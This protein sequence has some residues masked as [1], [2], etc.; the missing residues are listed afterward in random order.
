[1]KL[2]RLA[3]Y[4]RMALRLSPN[5]LAA[6]VSKK[7]SSEV[8]AISS[9]QRDWLRSTYELAP[10]H[11]FEAGLA[12]RCTPVAGC[13]TAQ[14]IEVIREI[15]THYLAHRFDLLG[16]G[17]VQVR[18]GMECAGLEGHRYPPGSAVATDPHG[19]WLAGRLNRSNVEA[20]Q[21]VWKLV[22][23]DYIPID[24]HV[25][26]KSGYRWDEK[27]WYRNIRF[28]QLQGVDV[29]VPWELARMQH[30]PHLAHAYALAAGG[31]EGFASPDD[32]AREFQNQVLDF[33]ST[34]PPRY[35]VN[36]ACTMDVGIRIANWLLARD[37]FIASGA[38]LDDKFE[39]T[40]IQSVYQH[41]QHIIDNLEWRVE[42]R[43]NHYLSDIVGLLFVAAYLPCSAK[44]D[45]WL[46]FSI[47]E[48]IVEVKGQFYEDG[49]NF[50][51][52]TSY[53]RL[54]AELVVYGSALIVG[55]PQSKRNATFSYDCSL[56]Q[57]EPKLNQAPLK[58]FAI[59]GSNIQ[60]PL[61]EWYWRRLERM[62][63][64]TF[65]IARPDG[66]SPQIGDNDSGRLFK[67]SPNYELL[68]F[69]EVRQRYENL[70]DVQELG[71]LKSY[72]LENQLDHR[73]L[74]AAIGGLCPRLKFQEF[75]IEFR[76]DTAMIE[77]LAQHRC[78]QSSI[79][80]EAPA[81]ISSPTSDAI[82][83]HQNAQTYV[84]SAIVIASETSSAL[85]GNLKCIAYPDFGLFIY[86]SERL[87]LAIRCGSIGL[88]GLG[89]HAH[90]DALSIEL[91]VDGR[92]LILDPGT[93]IYTP[94][95]QRRNDFR[96]VRSHFA[97]AIAG[98]EP[99]NLDLGTFILGNE[100]QATC[101][102][103][104]KSRFVGA[105]RCVGARIFREVKIDE[106]AVTVSDW[107]SRPDLT[108]C[109]L[110]PGSYGAENA[111]YSDGY[112]RLL[113]PRRLSFH[114]K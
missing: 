48:L 33:I 84:F 114:D 52:S 103:L 25:D 78:A 9:R 62:A 8:R 50:E 77:A 85:D 59:P 3:R 71:G 16:S 93:Y 43:G 73:H 106:Q 74:V 96:S 46:A 87:Y 42:L 72:P 14:Q 53:H 6:K 37:L 18:H 75:G 69:E 97:P 70:A 55:L 112:G 107:A 95:P 44:V 10:P 111:A 100:A 99:G 81:Q 40:F 60:S 49:A 21:S 108:L 109:R 17:W 39:E 83:R 12:Q 11:F 47:Q 26:F 86:K 15:S 76:C 82:S 98:V 54:S 34:N 66:L 91:W 35:G 90:N 104:S 32:Y 63:Q 23:F 20:S 58:V 92:A 51:A 57:C 79:E 105:Y 30:L 41:G 89:A 5:I 94:L 13:L 113:K 27:T 68:G 22:T 24:W 64:F 38:K 88:D 80:I 56:I 29:K 19:H 31:A 67:L 101:L 2:N 7:L 1:M 4:A 61:P 45:A 110:N 36:W 28:G 65:D 102:E